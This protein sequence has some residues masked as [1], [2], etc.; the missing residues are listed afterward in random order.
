MIPVNFHTG[1]AF[2]FI[3]F[4][5][6]WTWTVPHLPHKVD[7]IIRSSTDQVMTQTFNKRKFSS[8]WSI[9][10]FNFPIFLYLYPFT[11]LHLYIYIY[12][13]FFVGI[14]GSTPHPVSVEQNNLPS[15]Y[16][17]RPMISS[18]F[19]CY[20]VGGLPTIPIPSMYAIFTYI[21]L[22]FMVFYGKCR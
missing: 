9:F 22:I 15:S 10:T 14:F 16:G 12:R 11:Y 3:K 20:R 21:W 5:T 13:F 6:G 2:S 8:S 19:H 1:K 18:N 7:M 17:P 4:K